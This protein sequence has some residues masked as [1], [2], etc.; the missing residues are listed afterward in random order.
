MSCDVK[1][2]IASLTP[3]MKTSVK[4]KHPDLETDPLSDTVLGELQ[5]QIDDTCN[6]DTDS[7]SNYHI[8]S[9]L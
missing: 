1:P 7:P 5:C 2:G 8:S 6:L 9:T 3:Y 4:F